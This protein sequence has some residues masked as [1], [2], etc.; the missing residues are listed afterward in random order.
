[1]FHLIFILEFVKII[2]NYFQNIH[3][4]ILII[5]QLRKKILCTFRNIKLI[6]NIYTY[7]LRFQHQNCKFALDSNSQ[8]NPTFEKISQLQQNIEGNKNFVTDVEQAYRMDKQ[9]N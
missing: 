7:L 6:S 2:T 4:N 9:F 8:R 5:Y 1:M 3:S